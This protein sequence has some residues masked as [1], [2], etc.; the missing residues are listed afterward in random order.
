MK[1]RDIIIG[2]VF[3]VILTV[4]ILWIFRVKNNKTTNIPLPTPNIVQKVNNAFPNLNVPA[5]ADRA[6]LSDVT[7]GSNIGVATRQTTN[8]VYTLTIMINAPAPA[9]NTFY[10]ATLSSGTNSVN[11]GRLN[12]S[13]SGYLLNY[14]SNNNYS[15]YNKVAVSLGNS[16]ILEG[17]F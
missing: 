17:S 3:L 6:N 1:T 2:F 11:L 13:K 14:Q 10:Q 5:N 12:L 9:K 7:G 16:P 8:G 4:G 15:G